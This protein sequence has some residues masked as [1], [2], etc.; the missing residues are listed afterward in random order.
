M[1]LV[2]QRTIQQIF[3][4]EEEWGL[5]GCLYLGTVVSRKTA[6]VVVIVEEVEF[7]VWGFGGGWGVVVVGEDQSQAAARRGGNSAGSRAVCP[8]QSQE[9]R[10]VRRREEEERRS[11]PH[12]SVQG[13]GRSAATTADVL[14]A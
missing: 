8:A 2:L 10:G 1:G 5:A 14:L 6:V 13:K 7:K 11:H 3:D 12:P 4:G 9:L